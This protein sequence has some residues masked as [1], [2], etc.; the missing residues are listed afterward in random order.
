MADVSAATPTSE[1]FHLLRTRQ[2]AKWSAAENHAGVLVLA[3]TNRPS[4]VDAALLRPGRFD[5]LL[6]VPPP[7]M[8][9]RLQTLAVHTRSM[10][11]GADVNLAHVAAATA[12]YTGVACAHPGWSWCIRD[13]NVAPRALGAVCAVRTN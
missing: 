13:D 3:A 6:Y 1:I 7:D 8:E 12:L 2:T 9:G 11:L 10:P 4:A 5:M